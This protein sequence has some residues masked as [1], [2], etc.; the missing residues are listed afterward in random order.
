MGGRG[1]F[2]NIDSKDF[3]FVEGGQTYVKVGEVAGVEVLIRKGKLSVKAPEYS[4]SASKIYAVLQDGEIKHLSFYDENHKQVKL[5]DFMHTH[6]TNHV[7]PHVHFNMTHVKNEPGTPP[8]AEDYAII[9][10]INKW[11]RRH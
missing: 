11:L 2:K 9:E 1:A 10:K 3:T 8:S 7:K 5:I 4:H 6:G